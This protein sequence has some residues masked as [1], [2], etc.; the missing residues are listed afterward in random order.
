MANAGKP[1]RFA[2]NA[3]PE[4]D[5]EH[6]GAKTPVQ[7][8]MANLRMSTWIV[9]KARSSAGGEHTGVNTIWQNASPESGG[10]HSNVRT[11]GKNASSETG[12]EHTD[13]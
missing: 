11:D 9:E 2:Q 8:P 7:T 6:P 10:E 12:G 3:S 1:R 13:V 4:G 5:V